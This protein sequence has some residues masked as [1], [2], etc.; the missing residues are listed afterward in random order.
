MK[1]NLTVATIGV[2]ALLIAACNQQPAEKPGAQAA[3]KPAAAAE[4]KPEGKAP[5]KIAVMP[6]L[7][8]IDYFNA[9][10]KGAKE[11][12]KELGVELIYDGPHEQ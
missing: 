1:R 6:K 7:I 12:A 4:T 8:G 10:E 11:A 3:G 5:V 9:V 2:C